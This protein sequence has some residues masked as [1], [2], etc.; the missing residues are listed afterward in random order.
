[1]PETA[2]AP[3]LV[4]MG[5]F[6]ASVP[7]AGLRNDHRYDNCRPAGALGTTALTRVMLKGNCVSSIGNSF[8]QSGF[9]SVE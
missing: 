5:R 4:P 8:E 1:M 2:E 3:P 6:A 9:T 7:T